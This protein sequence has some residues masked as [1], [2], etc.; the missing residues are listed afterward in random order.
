L[1]PKQTETQTFSVVFQF[2]SQNHK[3]FFRFVLM[4]WT[5]IETTETNR[6]L[7]KQTETKSPRNVLY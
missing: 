6:I 1:E 5:G 4:F 7:S 3:H 2:V